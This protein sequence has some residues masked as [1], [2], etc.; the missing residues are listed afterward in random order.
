MKNTSINTKRYNKTAILMIVLLLIELK[1][2]G[3]LFP[4][5]GFK[6]II[7]IPIIIVICIVII[8]IGVFVTRKIS[9]LNSRISI[10]LVIFLINSLVIVQMYPQEFRPTA[11]EQIGYSI[12]VVNNFE[13]ISEEDL[14]LFVKDEYYPYDKSA[15]DDRERYIAALYKFRNEIKRDGSS[16]IYG[17]KDKPITEKTIINKQF[18]TGQDKL[19]WWLLETFY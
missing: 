3:N 4:W 11:L 15:P 7:V 13:T 6:A 18:E 16:F 14:Q 12:N 10:W 5:T 17:Q 9:K 2:L 1:L 8:T 19:I